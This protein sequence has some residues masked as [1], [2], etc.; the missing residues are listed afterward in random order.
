MKDLYAPIIFKRYYFQCTSVQ[1]SFLKRS[2]HSYM[3]V[4]SFSYLI[5]YFERTHN[6]T[7][8]CLKIVTDEECFEEINIF[9]CPFVYN[10][11]LFFSL[12]SRSIQ[13]FSNN[14]TIYKHTITYSNK[15]KKSM[16][17]MNLA[18]CF[19]PCRLYTLEAVEWGLLIGV[20]S[21]SLHQ[22]TTITRRK[23]I[24]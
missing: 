4:W 1:P 21:M 2:T 10:S 23:K 17:A 6:L 12:S 19:C 15:S 11:A 7:F 14:E 3:G 5:S 16:T 9:I 24:K 20:V 18:K 22:S 8:I 13:S